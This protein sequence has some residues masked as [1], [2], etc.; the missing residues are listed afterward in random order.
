MPGAAVTRHP[1][2]DHPLAPAMTRALRSF[3]VNF[4]ANSPGSGKRQAAGRGSD[5]RRLPSRAWLLQPEVDDESYGPEL[6]YK[7]WTC[8]PRDVSSGDQ[9]CLDN[10]DPTGRENRS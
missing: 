8:H 5:P 2:D 10:L 7:T 4:A 9:E 6:L 1:S 3:G